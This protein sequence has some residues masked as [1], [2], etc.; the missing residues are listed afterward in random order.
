LSDINL[1]FK[2]ATRMKTGRTLSALATQLEEI[3]GDL[4][5]LTSKA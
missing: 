4:L 5:L 2:K 3:G 1:L